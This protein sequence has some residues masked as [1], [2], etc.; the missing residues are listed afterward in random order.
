[1]RL[2][3]RNVG[4]LAWGCFLPSKLGWGR[5]GVS[6]LPWFG[7]EDKSPSWGEFPVHGANLIQSKGACSG[8]C[9]PEAVML[10]VGSSANG[11]FSS[12]TGI[13]KQESFQG[14]R[15]S[16]HTSLPDRESVL[17]VPRGPDG[18]QKLTS[19]PSEHSLHLNPGPLVVK[20][21][22]TQGFKG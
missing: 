4:V 17:V 21:C 1:M 6:W 16:F 22:L 2:F 5:A 12:L 18:K 13:W 8:P 9:Q 11:L 7:E 14:S 19:D 10:S 15:H 20:A 3:M